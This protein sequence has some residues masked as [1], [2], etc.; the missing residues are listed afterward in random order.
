[1]KTFLL[2]LLP[3]CSAL[4]F[5]EYDLQ[6]EDMNM[7]STV[8]HCIEWDENGQRILVGT[9]IGFHSLDLVSGEWFVAEE[10]GTIGREVVSIDASCTQPEFIMTGRCDAQYNGYLEVSPDLGQ[11]WISTYF[12]SG[13]EFRSFHRDILV[14]GRCY[15]GGISTPGAPGEF[16]VSEDNGLNWTVVDIPMSAVTDIAQTVDGTLFISGVYGV[17]RSTDGGLTWETASSGMGGS[18]FSNAIA[19]HPT[20]PDILFASDQNHIYKTEDGGDSWTAVGDYFCMNI[21]ICPWN[22]DMIAVVELDYL[23]TGSNDG[24]ETWFSIQGDIPGNPKD[25]IFCGEDEHLYAITTYNGTFRTPVSFSGTEG[26][27][28][29]GSSGLEIILSE[30]PVINSPVVTCSIPTA[31]SV[32]LDV[33]DASGRL[34][35]TLENRELQAGSHQVVLDGSDLMPGILFLR[36]TAGNESTVRKVVVGTR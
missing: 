28:S 13:G 35:E 23:L 19:A 3:F 34:V 25:V 6:W 14:P 24:G 33:F 22:P 4:A 18:P 36:L 31:G 1:M 16:V 30:N 17:C 15:A 32:R 8:G 5:P 20:D 2:V 27:G 29:Q 11:N 21:E 7:G 12:S 10:E 9:H 26:G